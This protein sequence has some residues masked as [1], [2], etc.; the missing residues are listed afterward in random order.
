MRE[1]GGTLVGVVALAS[2]L[3]GCLVDRTGLFPGGEDA[4]AGRD[5]GALDA[6]VEDAGGRDAGS[7]DAGSVDAGAIDAGAIDAGSIDAGSID[8]GSIDAGGPRDAGTDAFVPVDACAPG[9]E[10][11]NGVDDDCDESIADDGDDEAWLGG[12][13]DAP[14]DTDQ[15]ED[16]AWACTGGAMVCVG[17][18]GD[19]P[20]EVETCNGA[21]DDCDG[22]TDESDPMV[23]MACDG[24]DA[25]LCE[26]GTYTGCADGALACDDASGDSTETCDGTDEDCDGSIDEGG[27]C[28]C[29]WHEDAGHAYLFCTGSWGWWGARDACRSRGYEL[30]TVDG[31]TEQRFLAGEAGS[32]EWWIGANDI[33]AEG[34]WVWVADGSAVT[35]DAW[36]TDQ[37]NNHRGN[38]HCGV[39]EGDRT[40]DSGVPGGW[41]DQQCWEGR[42]F[43][44]E[45]AP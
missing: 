6:A 19:D 10:L 37:P 22:A 30:V 26:E 25:D 1:R 44:C 34:T 11:C 27:V 42:N 13:C 40:S 20:D 24:E 18:G 15:C 38:Q 31:E 39:L 21:D 36:R 2:M 3:S 14:S 16:G 7:V 41:G 43:I 32:S 17:D 12:A 9:P 45:A 35:Y 33:D 5:G 4:G 8:A 29:T 28:P 23:G